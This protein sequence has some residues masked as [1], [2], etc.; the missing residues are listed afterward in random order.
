MSCSWKEK[1][2][3]ME[4]SRV[5]TMRV[6]MTLRSSRCSRKGFSWSGFAWS[7]IWKTFLSKYIPAGGFKPCGCVSARADAGGWEIVG[8]ILALRVR[9]G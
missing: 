9:G 4:I 1:Q 6:I 5:T 3:I 2:A 8:G 7:R